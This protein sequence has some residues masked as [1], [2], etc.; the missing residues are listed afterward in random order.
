[1]KVSTSILLA[2]VILMLIPGFAL[3]A[4]L[5]SY[6]QSSGTPLNETSATIPIY[7]A[8]ARTLILFNNTVMPGNFVPSPISYS[9]GPVA[10]NPVNDE[11]YAVVSS[12]NTVKVMSAK[13]YTVLKNIHVGANPSAIAVDPKKGYVYVLNQGSGTVTMISPNDTVVN[14]IET[15]NWPNL[16]TI[17][18]NN[19]LVY[20]ANSSTG[21]IIVLSPS[22]SKPLAQAKLNTSFSALFYVHAVDR[23]IA[24]YIQ[25]T[26]GRDV[27]HLYSIN[28][29]TLKVVKYS[30][31]G[32]ALRV[33]SIAV[34]PNNAVIYFLEGN[35]VQYV[36]AR[37][38]SVVAT[39]N[40]G[41]VYIPYMSVWNPAN[42]FIYAIGYGTN[43]A[44]VLYV[45]N[46]ANHT[47]L[48]AVPLPQ[49]NVNSITV[50]PSKGYV[51]ITAGPPNPLFVV[52]P[53]DNYVM[54][55][56]VGQLTPGGMAYDSANNCIFVTLP[57]ANSVAVINAS[58]MKVVKY[59]GTGL[60]PNGIT[61][62]PG[63][64]MIYVANFRNFTLSAINPT[65][66]NVTATV[67]VGKGPTAMAY[68][69]F[70]G[71]LYVANYMSDTV[72][73]VNLRTGQLVMNIQAGLGPNG[74]VFS[75]STNKVYVS[76]YQSS[77]I[78]IIDASNN[79]VV[80]T[81][82]LNFN[83][84]FLTLGD[85]NATLIVGGPNK[86]LLIN[87]SNVS[88]QRLI[89]LP[90]SPTSLVYD[91]VNGLYYVSL[92]NNVVLA[93]YSTNF[94]TA[95]QLT[96]GNN[97]VFLAVNTKNGSVYVANQNSG[98]ISEIIVKPFKTVKTTVT[99]ATTT[100]NSTATETTSSSPQAVTTTSPGGLDVISVVVVLAALAVGVYVLILLRG[101]TT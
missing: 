87:A 15:Y 31:F 98:T 95:G 11:I 101:R 45:I 76:N 60:L 21:Q 82:K 67:P 36:N 46:P 38:L 52:F 78:L 79:Q 34:N 43:Y 26:Y 81:I 97:P 29:D 41:P 37:N 72:S 63:D 51:Y 9:L 2:L 6:A 14:V 53:P 64:G 99:N 89:Q 85:D 27:V 48:A 44:R 40:V 25:G 83:P 19:G 88:N 75:P 77:N 96:V 54:G 69:P 18:T 47:L 66:L 28:P 32:A 10:Y 12:S 58:T 68:D 17:N 23:L 20:V 1:M 57:T 13:N 71:Y 7:G 73:V 62:L 30:S 16:M 84:T 33:N 80:G 39:Y 61:V 22:S 100:V 24:I 94:T 92:T 3:L 90:A 49:S 8:V 59:I 65:T 50:N 93:L 86:L 56:F 91:P 4:L 55:V 70:N 42:G 5:P 35:L 74:V